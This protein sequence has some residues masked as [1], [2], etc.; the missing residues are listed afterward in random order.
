MLLIVTEQGTIA[1]SIIG[2][3]IV[4]WQIVGD[5][6][7]ENSKNSLPPLALSNFTTPINNTMPIH[8]QNMLVSELVYL[9]FTRAYSNSCRFELTDAPRNI[10]TK[11]PNKII[12]FLV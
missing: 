5:V 11:S 3:A 6:F 2:L 4:T 12:E 9:L 10:T 8:A 7:T 1:G